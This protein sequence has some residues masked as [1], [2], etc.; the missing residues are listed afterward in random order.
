MTNPII[1]ID[2]PTASGKGTV[3]QRVAHA[4]QFHYLDS[5]ALYRL[6]ALSALREKLALEDE[7]AIACIASHLPCHFKGEQIW[8]DKEEVSDV[9]RAE[10]VGNAAS[11]IAVFPGI[12]KALYSLQR[13][14]SKPP[15]L[16]ADG[17]DMGTVV[18]PLADLKIYLT[19]SVDARAERR[20]K[21]LISKGFTANIDDLVKDLA[22]RDARDK[23]R[24]IA[25]LK[26]AQD[27]YILDTSHLTVEQT[28]MEVLQQYSAISVKK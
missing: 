21:Q 17:R 10:E 13:S 14:F 3:A 24:S 9:I 27:A 18:F 8:L 5:G 11:K 16:V 1:T 4:L 15:G 2:G 19:A 28:V 25:P 23:N 22:E 7:Q 20:F 26:P 12:R 6:T